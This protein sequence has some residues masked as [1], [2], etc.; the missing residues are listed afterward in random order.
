MS[1]PLVMALANRGTDS[2]RTASDRVLPV[3]MREAHFTNAAYEG[4]LCKRTIS[5][6]LYGLRSRHEVKLFHFGIGTRRP[7]PSPTGTVRNLP[8]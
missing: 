8:S 5:P 3:S 4:Y 7:S 2:L 6:M 1:K